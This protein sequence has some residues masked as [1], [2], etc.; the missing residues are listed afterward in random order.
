MVSTMGIRENLV[1]FIND[2]PSNVFKAMWPA[3]TI[4]RGGE[5][6]ENKDF[7]KYFD[8][9]KVGAQELGLSLF[10]TFLS[11]FGF[12]KGNLNENIFNAFET[13]IWNLGSWPKT[14]NFSDLK[15]KPAL[16]QSAI[17]F[18]W[19]CV[20]PANVIKM[21]VK[22]SEYSLIKGAD[23]VRSGINNI[24]D[25]GFL[26]QTIFVK[27]RVSQGVGEKDPLD[28]KQ[29]EA[30][31][32]EKGE[33]DKTILSQQEKL[34]DMGY[35][36]QNRGEIRASIRELKGHKRHLDRANKKSCKAKIEKSKEYREVPVFQANTTDEISKLKN[37][38]SEGSINKPLIEAQIEAREGIISDLRH[39]KPEAQLE[40]INKFKA[41]LQKAEQ[42]E[43]PQ[44]FSGTVTTAGGAPAASLMSG[45][46]NIQEHVV[47]QKEN[48]ATLLGL[49][50][51][52]TLPDVVKAIDP[53]E[54]LNFYDLTSKRLLE[55]AEDQYDISDIL[56]KFNHN[57]KSLDDMTLRDLS[58]FASEKQGA[59]K[60][61]G[62]KE[63][64]D[65]YRQR[66][67]DGLKQLK[68][69]ALP[70]SLALQ[71]ALVA[72][73][74]LD[75]LAAQVAKRA[76][77]LKCN[78]EQSQQIAQNLANQV[79]KELS[80][81]NLE[82]MR[83]LST[84]PEDQN[85]R[86]DV[87]DIEV[88][89]EFP[90]EFNRTVSTP[91]EFQAAIREGFAKLVK[92][93]DDDGNNIT[94]IKPLYINV[95]AEH[96]QQKIEVAR[97]VVTGQLEA[98][99]NHGDGQNNETHNG[100]PLAVI[101]HDSSGIEVRVDK[102]VEAEAVKAFNDEAFRLNLQKNIDNA[103]SPEEKQRWT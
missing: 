57:G 87:K 101:F 37:Q 14:S 7:Y 63:A 84:Q 75:G 4:G 99:T 71:E 11:G 49:N 51:G 38:L 79:G 66:G 80:E 36:D 18:A 50:D 35:N 42:G 95:S 39:Q 85:L 43:A 67:P 96:E 24:K 28:A 15:K 27:A 1:E 13:M 47:K 83:R 76:E 32:R 52:S 62:E 40:L 3:G 29:K 34:S 26:M 58:D 41:D 90:G 31:E 19:Q 74:L 53:D 72:Q 93:L 9:I 21:V 65:L 23:L 103:D 20:N 25:F 2:L 100:Q 8:G 44:A 54:D 17:L 46:K 73:G 78:K 59:L 12:D 88:K 30:I 91:A 86:T 5:K 64:F 98:M 61:D 56:G 6:P 77:E 22:L 94:V 68:K 81:S 48:Q 97:F 55:M 102:K 60:D 92:D 69:G 89:E 70:D 10:R 16:L 45:L 82:A 33:L